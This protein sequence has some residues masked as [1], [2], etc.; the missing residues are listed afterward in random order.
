MMVVWISY[1]VLLHEG[2]PFTRNAQ[3]MYFIVF[4]L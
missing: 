3:L 2:I 4:V 1:F